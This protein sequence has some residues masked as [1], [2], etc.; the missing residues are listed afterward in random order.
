MGYFDHHQR[1]RWPVRV[2]RIHNAKA[3]RT[4]DKAVE[5]LANALQHLSDSSTCAFHSVQ[6][7]SCLGP[8]DADTRAAFDIIESARRVVDAAFNAENAA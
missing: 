2:K 4:W 8:V 1:G 5:T 6:R 3:K 7:C